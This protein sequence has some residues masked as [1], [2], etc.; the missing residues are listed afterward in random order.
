MELNKTYIIRVTID[1]KLLTYKGKVLS[2]SPFFI[3]FLDKFD[4]L[5]SV[6][7]RNIE[8]YEECEE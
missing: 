7:K 5:I 1:G 4:K 2:D 6:N 8:S 3:T